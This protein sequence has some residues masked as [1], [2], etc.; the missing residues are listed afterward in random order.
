MKHLIVFSATILLIMSCKSTVI[1][2]HKKLDSIAESYVKLAL[3]LG[4]YDAN[5]VDAYYGPDEWKP[6]PTSLENM[7]PFP[8]QTFRSE[9]DSLLNLLNHM[10]I[11][12]F[13]K[14]WTLRYNFLTKAVASLQTK[15]EMI[16]GHH[17]NYDEEARQLFDVELADMDTIYFRSIIRTLNELLPGD[18][19]LYQRIDEFSSQ[20]NIPAD[21]L[22]HAF[23]ATLDECR[24][25]TL[26]HIELPQNERFDLEFVL[27]KPWSAYNWYKGNYQSLIQVNTTHP[28]SAY[29]IVS[30]ATHEG[31][32]GHH[33]NSVLIEKY[34]YRDCG[35]VEFCISPLYAPYSVIME[36]LANAA[37]DITFPDN[38]LQLFMKNV[39][40]P[41]AGL[42]TS[43]I[44]RYIEVRHYV[45]ALEFARLNTL[46]A[47]SNGDISRE[48]AIDQLQTMALIPLE[49]TAR[50]LKFSETYGAYSVTYVV[51][52]QLIR[53]YLKQ[54]GGI[55][56]DSQWQIMSELLS[57][58]RTP[59]GMSD[60]LQ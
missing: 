2:N 24:R 35:W 33:V 21:K 58:P 15:I 9:A 54:H 20:F 5:Y 8:Y 50:V 4:Q 1:V 31:Y 19:P 14:L 32:P 55:D 12:R 39:L 57:T 42:G 38:E 17:Y 43:D 51:G 48:Q 46:R 23:R 26:A 60:R 30:L 41:I 16:H 10:N 44:E 34:L 49:K 13:D 59:S 37:I 52:L 3:R 53:D 18:K 22:E 47:F 56:S 6:A 29:G 11:A 27:D 25:R 45:E 28:I 40:F 7:P 36:G